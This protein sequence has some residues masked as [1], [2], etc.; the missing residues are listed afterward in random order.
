MLTPLGRSQASATGRRLRMRLAALG[1]DA[2]REIV[3]STMARAVETAMLIKQAAFP[4]ATLKPDPALRE[5]APCVPVRAHSM[6][7]APC[8]C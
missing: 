5:G 7:A 6:A 3:H 8:A 4:E 1:V 2:P